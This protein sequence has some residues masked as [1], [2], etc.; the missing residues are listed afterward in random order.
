L[1][2]HF[3]LFQSVLRLQVVRFPLQNCSKRICCLRPH[4]QRLASCAAPQRSFDGEL[5]SQRCLA[6]LHS[7]LVAL[8]ADVCLRTVAEQH[9]HSPQLFSNSAA[10]FCHAYIHMLSHDFR[11][12]TENSW[13]SKESVSHA[14]D[15]S[16]GSTFTVILHVDIRSSS[17]EKHWGAK[18]SM[19]PS[20]LAVTSGHQE[21]QYRQINRTYVSM[22]W[23]DVQLSRAI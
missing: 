10:V 8:Q 13:P 5:A 19:Q 20:L 6:V 15:Y 17:T 3:T 21:F 22:P 7:L 18:E 16:K 14:I 9:L 1:E 4:P 2:S 23:R 11:T 12:M